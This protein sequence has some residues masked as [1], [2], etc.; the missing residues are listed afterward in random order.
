MASLAGLKRLMEEGP[1][2]VQRSF[3][4]KELV[5][6]VPESAWGETFHH[7]DRRY[8]Q[9]PGGGIYP[10]ATTFLG[11]FS[12]DKY[13][14]EWRKRV[15]EAEAD[16]IVERSCKRGEDIHK[17]LEHYIEGL[18]YDAE[19]EVG[20]FHFMY[21]QH[22][23]V[24]DKDLDSWIAIEH[25]LYSDKLKVAGRS[26]LICY[27]RGRLSILDYKN[28]NYVG[29]TDD[30]TEYFLQGALYA[31]MFEE[32]YGVKVEDIVILAAEDDKKVEKAQVFITKVDKWKDQIYSMNQRFLNE[33]ADWYDIPPLLL[34]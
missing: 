1:T 19:A 9:T 13:L 15:G 11:Y 7:N 23:R 6:L 32:M 10:S 12:D 33:N 30:M 16:R 27:F 31:I 2:I 25:A 28:K 17:A 21:E 22:R 3:P 20:E 24:L 8:Y 18:T 14:I 5:E 29:R 4:K 34:L 26:D